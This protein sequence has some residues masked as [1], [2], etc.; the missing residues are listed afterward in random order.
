MG[1][2]VVSD[3]IEET[4]GTAIIDHGKNA[5]RA[6]I[7]FIG[8]HVARESRQGPVKEVGVQARLGL[9]SPPPRPSSGWWQRARRPDGLATGANS[10]GDRASRP[11][12]RAAPPD[13]SRGGYSDCPVAPAQRGRR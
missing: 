9:F 1:G 12:P 2:I 5:E 10:L 8:S 11:R 13:Q 7:E 6:I 3:V 4:L